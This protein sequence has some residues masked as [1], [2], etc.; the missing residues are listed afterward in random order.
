MARR[1]SEEPVVE[2][3]VENEPIVEEAV[4]EEAVVEEPFTEEVKTVQPVT[5]N[6]NKKGVLF[7]RNNYACKYIYNNEECMITAKGKIKVDNVD[8]IKKPLTAGLLLR[9][10]D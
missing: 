8:L 2:E 6:G 5:N 4:V 3:L 10:I 9:K 7:S 1:H